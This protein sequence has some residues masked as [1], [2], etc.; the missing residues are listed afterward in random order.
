MP[1]CCAAK[2]TKKEIGANH[3]AV[4]CDPPALKSIR[5]LYL[6]SYCV[7]LITPRGCSD[8]STI[9]DLFFPNSILVQKRGY[10]SAAQRIGSATA[11][12]ANRCITTF[13]TK[14]L[15]HSHMAR[16]VSSIRSLVA[17]PFEAEPFHLL[18]ILKELCT[19][20]YIH[21]LVYYVVPRQSRELVLY[22]RHCRATS[23]FVSVRSCSGF[24][25]PV[26][27][28]RAASTTNCP[29]TERR[30][31]SSLET[32]DLACDRTRSPYAPSKVVPVTLHCCTRFGTGI[33][34]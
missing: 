23:A 24:M 8:S 26:L 31:C 9:H 20:R 10:D 30:A 34:L 32:V 2:S 3:L 18:S 21:K 25:L 14:Q 12:F 19:C 33:R 6:K 5:E 7:S 4:E 22:P 16:G 13:T 17:T 28:T 27:E 1:Y 15:Q 11:S 29:P